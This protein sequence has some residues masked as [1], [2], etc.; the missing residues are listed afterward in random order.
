MQVDFSEIQDVESYVTVPAGVYVCRVAEIREGA[1]RDGHPR[2]AMRL[3]VADGDYA[4]RTAGWDGLS[5]T[6]RGLP[7]V[8]GILA[9]FGFDV[10]GMLDLRPDDLIGR[11]ARVQ[12]ITETREDAT[13]KQVA[14]LR[15]PFLG[16]AAV[17]EEPTPF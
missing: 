15:V 16:Y 10:S 1:T 4:G 12:F 3:E 8:K 13:G 7:R 14:R 17:E 11:R 6:D 5:W 9:R 2:W